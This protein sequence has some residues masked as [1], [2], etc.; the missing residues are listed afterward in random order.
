MEDGETLERV[1][2][3]AVAATSLGVLKVRLRMALSNVN[4]WE[5][6][7]A[8]AGEG[9]VRGSLRVSSKPKPF[10]DSKTAL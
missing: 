5:T 2:R 6:P 1:A 8:T 7:P 10:C 3:E 9:W 4:Y